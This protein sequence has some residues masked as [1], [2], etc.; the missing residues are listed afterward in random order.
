MKVLLVAIGPS[1]PGDGLLN[2]VEALHRGGGT[3]HLVSRRPPTPAL[4]AAL[5]GITPLPLGRL[6]SRVSWPFA[7]PGALR[8]LRFDPDRLPAAARLDRTAATRALLAACD[9]VVAVDQAAIPAVWLAARRH[10]RVTALNGVPAAVS[11]YGSHRP[12]GS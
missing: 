5:D 11:R 3:V 4:A 7:L 9:V 12:N 8:R 2:A 6:A 1:T 10:P